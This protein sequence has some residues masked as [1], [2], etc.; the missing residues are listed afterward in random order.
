MQSVRWKKL[1][2]KRHNYRHLFYSQACMWEAGPTISQSDCALLLPFSFECTRSL[3]IRNRMCQRHRSP[4]CWCRYSPHIGIHHNMNTYTTCSDHDRIG[5]VHSRSSYHGNW[6]CLT[7]TYPRQQG[8]P[9]SPGLLC[10][11]DDDG[12]PTSNPDIQLSV[13]APSPQLSDTVKSRHTTEC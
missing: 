9:A 6:R 8:R 4:E 7:G 5:I 1:C 2:C 12:G 13:K 10:I 3:D 11:E